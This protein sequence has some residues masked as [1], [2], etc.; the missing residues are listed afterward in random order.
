MKKLARLR[1]LPPSL[2]FGY[3]KRRHPWGISDISWCRWCTLLLSVTNCP[4]LGATP[5]VI[6]R[7]YALAE[8]AILWRFLLRSERLRAPLLARSPSSPATVTWL[9]YK[10]IGDTLGVSP[11]FHGAGGG[12]RTH[13]PVKTTDFESVSSASSDT[14]A[15][16]GV[17]IHHLP[18]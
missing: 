13:T 1:V 10:N 7:A 18:K 16:T 11:I 3:K 8:I 12:T 4:V 5:P 2:S 14:P 17:I 9:W 15:A 6:S